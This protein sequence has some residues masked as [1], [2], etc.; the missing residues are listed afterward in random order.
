MIE[1]L[2]N[3]KFYEKNK[4]YFKE[5]SLFEVPYLEN[6]VYK[7]NCFRSFFFR[8][9]KFTRS[10]FSI[11]NLEKDL[12]TE[13]NLKILRKKY[14][15]NS[16]LQFLPENKQEIK[17]NELFFNKNE[18]LISDKCVLV[19]KIV[20][21]V[22]DFKRL[23]SIPLIEDFPILLS[24]ATMHKGKEINII[25]KNLYGKNEVS[26]TIKIQDKILFINDNDTDLQYE[27]I[28][29][30]LYK[31]IDDLYNH[32]FHNTIPERIENPKCEKCRWK[33]FC[34]YM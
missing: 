18:F 7:N 28:V 17:I 30:G 24:L 6:E 3:K 8:F 23:N 14:L 33:S 26:H 2:T 16:G 12:E 9:K 20:K 27:S 10:D 29:I 32:V 22:S 15:L 34:K 4:N 19:F 1:K 25:Y 31:T 5:I 11:Y 21:N 13:L